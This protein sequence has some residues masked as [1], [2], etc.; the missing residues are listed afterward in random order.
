[1]LTVA[2]CEGGVTTADVALLFDTDRPPSPMAEGSVLPLSSQEKVS[3]YVA[4][5]VEKMSQQTAR[6]VASALERENAVFPNSIVDVRACGAVSVRKT[7]SHA[8]TVAG[9][10]VTLPVQTGQE[11]ASLG[12][13]FLKAYEAMEKIYSKTDVVFIVSLDVGWNVLPALREN[14]GALV[15][16][17]D[18]V[19]GIW[20]VH[21][22]DARFTTTR[23][24]NNLCIAPNAAETPGWCLADI[25]FSFFAK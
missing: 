12:D 24:H 21:A 5:T 16:S 14:M 9:W 25:L 18:A 19:E 1:M 7:K 10:T 15:L 20:T 17:G 22:G 11:A 8:V 6:E 13:F 3:M 4:D 2:K 23:P